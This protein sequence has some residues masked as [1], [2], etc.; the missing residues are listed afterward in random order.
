M[1]HFILE[2]SWEW[3]LDILNEWSHQSNQLFRASNQLDI[4]LEMEEYFHLHFY[5]IQNN[6]T[7]LYQFLF[8]LA[9]SEWNEHIE[10][11]CIYDSSLCLQIFWTQK[12]RE[13]PMANALRNTFQCHQLLWK[14]LDPVKILFFPI[15]L[16]VYMHLLQLF[17]ILQ[18]DSQSVIF[19]WMSWARIEFVFDLALRFLLSDFSLKPFAVSLNSFSRI[20][21]YFY[22]L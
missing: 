5:R 18:T 16:F 10:A 14:K 12:L 3:Y 9:F 20:N 13:T 4:F 22:H 11:L 1:I 15:M 2:F 19:N 21:W 8:S 17:W 7:Q 6:T